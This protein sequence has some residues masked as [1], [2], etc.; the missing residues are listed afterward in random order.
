MEK[1]YLA[2]YPF[3]SEAKDFMKEKRMELNAYLREKGEKRVRGALIEGNVPKMPKSLP[4]PDA[5]LY[6][7]ASYAAAR[8]ILSSLKSRFLINRYAIAEAKRASSYLRSEEERVL[9][10]V[11]D[12]LGIGFVKT[13]RRQEV[14]VIDYV[15]YS[16]KDSAYRLVNRDLRK[17]LVKIKEAEKARLMEEAIKMR[18]QESLPINAK[19]PEEIIESAG[20]IRKELPKEE[21]S[22]TEVKVEDFAP[23]ISKMI[24]DLKMNVNLPHTA[25]WSLAVYLVNA[26]MPV[27]KIIQL[28]RYAPDF[29]ERTT[30]YQIEHVKRKGYSTPSCSSMDSYGLCVANCRCG[31]PIR[32]RSRE[33]WRKQKE[34]EEKKKKGK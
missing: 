14:P 9:E 13:E 8:M 16:P 23:C 17:G 2:R 32:Y 25:R 11:A 29:N 27:E 18:I 34:K 22:A 31:S 6:E 15:K 3:L 4:N 21:M 1:K 24:E 19:M 12:D 5:Y 10:R 33:T 7:I 28:F 30:R 20:R 26:K